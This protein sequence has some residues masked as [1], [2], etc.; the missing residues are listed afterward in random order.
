LFSAKVALDGATQ[1]K[2][3]AAHT[4]DAKEFMSEVGFCRRKL[5]PAT[6]QNTNTTEAQISHAKG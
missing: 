2:V 1:T 4:A 5:A 3:E 6:L